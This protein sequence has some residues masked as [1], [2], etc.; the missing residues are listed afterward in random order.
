MQQFRKA[1]MPGTKQY[2]KRKAYP[3]KIPCCTDSDC[4]NSIQGIPTYCLCEDCSKLA[5]DP[6][7]FFV[8]PP[9]KTH[10]TRLKCKNQ[11]IATLIAHIRTK[12]T[13]DEH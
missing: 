1:W 4:I 8:H 2:V 10:L 6:V 3:G 11:A 13:R 9:T 5:P 12:M 7:L